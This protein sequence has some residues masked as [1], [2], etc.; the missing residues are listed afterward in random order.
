MKYKVG[1]LVILKIG[2]EFSDNDG[3]CAII[4]AYLEGFTLPYKCVVQS[5]P[6]QFFLY[7]EQHMEKV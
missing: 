1:D 2:K 3:E 4:I 7:S 6:T 5:D